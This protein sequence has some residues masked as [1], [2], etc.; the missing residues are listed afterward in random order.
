MKD[1]LLGNVHAD[2]NESRKLF[3]FLVSWWICEFN[4]LCIEG[5]RTISHFKRST[6]EAMSMETGF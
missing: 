3:F 6:F 1:G 2:M 5:A 4:F